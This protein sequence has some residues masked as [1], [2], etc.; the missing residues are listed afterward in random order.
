MTQAMEQEY[1]EKIAALTREKE[2]AVQ[3]QRMQAEFESTVAELRLQLEELHANLCN[4][5]KAR[6]TKEDGQSW[7]EHE[8]L[9]REW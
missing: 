2:F 4:A 7:A 6:A 8:E 3:G 1:L 5:S 9:V